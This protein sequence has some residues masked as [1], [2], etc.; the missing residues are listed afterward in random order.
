MELIEINGK[1]H[2]PKIVGDQQ[3]VKNKLTEKG[4]EF[5]EKIYNELDIITKTK[6]NELLE[7]FGKYTLTGLL[8]YIYSKYPEECKEIEQLYFNSFLTYF[9]FWINII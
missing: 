5:A 9:S 6:L 2:D 7:R 3:I 1:I 4:K 8:H